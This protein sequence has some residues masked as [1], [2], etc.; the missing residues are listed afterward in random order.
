MGMIKLSLPSNT[1]LGLPVD[2]DTHEP[3][4]ERVNGRIEAAYTTAELGWA[5]AAAGYFEAARHLLART[6]IT[7]PRLF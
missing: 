2:P 4:Y 3:R 5:L 7:Q 1:T 6:Q